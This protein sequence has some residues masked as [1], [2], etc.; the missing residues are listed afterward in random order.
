MAVKITTE[1]I[2]K[3]IRPEKQEFTLTELNDHVKGWIEPLKIGPVWVMYK[4]KA[5]ESG[6]PLNQVASF[7]FD[8]AFYGDVLVVPPQQM[9]EEWGTID[10]EEKQYTSEQVDTGFLTSLQAA[11]MI[12]RFLGAPGNN[13]SDQSFI[14]E[15]WSYKPS[16]EVDDS[17]TDFYEK[18]YESIIKIR[19]DRDNVLFEDEE[20]IIKTKSTEDKVKTIKQMLDHFIRVEEYEKCA[21]LQKLIQEYEHNC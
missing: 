11:L 19:K 6:E 20:K 18:T 15:E 13:Q 21:E 2:V 14:K 8:T 12:N 17:V 5:K 1:A 10:D 16:D 4:E 7:F 9:P 3:M